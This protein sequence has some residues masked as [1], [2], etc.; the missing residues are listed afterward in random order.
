MAS[1][2]DPFTEE[3]KQVLPTLGEL[4]DIDS[5]PGHPNQANMVDARA[6]TLDHSEYF[7]LPP[8]INHAARLNA[9]FVVRETVSETNHRWRPATEFDE[10]VWGWVV[11]NYVDRGLQ[12]FLPDGTFYREVRTTASDV[13]WLPFGDPP[14]FDASSETQLAALIKRLVNDDDTYLAAFI[15]MIMSALA[16]T[17]PPP[18]AYSQS[19]NPLVGRPLALANMGWSLKLATNP[20]RNESDL[21]KQ[22]QAQRHRPYLE[23]E[24]TKQ[25]RFALKFG[26]DGLVG[27]FKTLKTDE[28]SK[29]DV[30]IEPGH[31]LDL[32]T[33]Y[34]YF[35]SKKVR[36]DGRPLSP[37]DATKNPDLPAFWLDPMDYDSSKTT[38]NWEEVSRRYEADRNRQLQ[39]FGALFDPFAPITG[40][41]SILPKR[42]LSLAPWAWETA[43]K[44]MTTFFHAGR[45]W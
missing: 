15:D 45:K 24:G 42:R 37:I 35:H 14:E 43:L 30:P 13:R 16:N 41:C 20:N 26:D 5:V 9:H 40:F 18:S 23:G 39:I 11:V 27:Y 29:A 32:D 38:T 22:N 31:D 33:F 7:Q 8:S 3:P 12:F 21:K 44:R 28:I 36:E 34:T 25:Y 1:Y 4:Y 2:V 19:L 17:V 6:S 10:P